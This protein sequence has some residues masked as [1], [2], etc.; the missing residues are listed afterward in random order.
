MR[1]DPPRDGFSKKLQCWVARRQDSS[2]VEPAQGTPAVALPLRP[3]GWPGLCVVSRLRTEQHGPGAH[4][5]ASQLC[6][7]F[8]PKG[9]RRVKV[10]L[11]PWQDFLVQ[12][13]EPKPTF[14][15]RCRTLEEPR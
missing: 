11:I 15:W 2:R 7:Q 4:T 5:R 9:T 12:T 8:S 14:I 3:C 1:F 10:I 6:G 13:G